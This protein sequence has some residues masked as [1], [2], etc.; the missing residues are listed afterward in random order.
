MIPK[1]LKHQKLKPDQYPTF[2]HLAFLK[3]GR[4]FCIEKGSPIL[5]EYRED[6]VKNI[7]SLERESKSI[8]RDQEYISRDTERARKE[9]L[10]L[11]ADKY[12]KEGQLPADLV[13]NKPQAFTVIT[14]YGEVIEKA[15]R[16]AL[17]DQAEL[18]KK[19]KENLRSLSEKYAAGIEKQAEALKSEGNEFD[20]GILS[21]EATKARND[22]DYFLEIVRAKDPLPEGLKS[23]PSIMSLDQLIVGV[24]NSESSDTVFYFYNDG[25]TASKKPRKTGTWRVEE[26]QVV[27]DW[28][29]AKLDFLTFPPDDPNRFLAK[30]NNGELIYFNRATPLLTDPVLGEWE[31][32]DNPNIIFTFNSDKSVDNGTGNKHGK[33]QKTE[34]SYLI[35]WS[36]GV[37]W[38][39]EM[40]DSKI[41]HIS[42]PNGTTNTLVRK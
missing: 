6:L 14:Y 12:R 7:D 42:R 2:D 21:K 4:D 5:E 27:A 40:E 36:N 28:G 33:W 17:A 25:T 39:L 37:S 15:L 29:A 13:S 32:A 30:Y 22:I 24:W 3:R 16:E 23:D 26:E 20:A 9:N 18:E 31:V 1:Y 35:T 19:M 11:I 38:G 34:D 41:L 10:E 8:L